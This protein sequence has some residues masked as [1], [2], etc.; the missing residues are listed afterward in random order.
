MLIVPS[1]LKHQY[2]KTSNDLASIPN[3]FLENLL[4]MNVSSLR[5][6]H[7]LHKRAAITYMFNIH[8]VQYFHYL[9][10]SSS[11]QPKRFLQRHKVTL[12]TFRIF[13]M[14]FHFKP[15]V[16]FKKRSSL[17]IGHSSKDIYRVKQVQLSEKPSI[18]KK[19]N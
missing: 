3:L 15:T 10:T 2:L 16:L 13:E 19:N 1:P 11:F 6:K 12:V 7:H 18:A 14:S 5:D 8:Y 17:T 9:P 4:Q